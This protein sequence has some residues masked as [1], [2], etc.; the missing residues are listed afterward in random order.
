MS[1]GVSRAL[2]VAG[3]ATVVC[4]ALATSQA[5]AQQ[6]QQR[7]VFL[8]QAWSQADRE[9]YYQ[10][11]QGSTVISYDVFLNLEVAGSE[12]LLMSEANSER[13]GLTTQAP[14][15][16]NPDGLPIGLAKGTLNEQGVHQG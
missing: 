16:M 7:V 12:E 10:F 11:S 2:V 14:G 5:H 8:D 9:W 1:N 6:P 4:G 15:P 3:L 13:F